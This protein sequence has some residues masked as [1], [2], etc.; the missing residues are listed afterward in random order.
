MC[1]FGAHHE[2]GKEL[3]GKILPLAL[4]HIPRKDC[5]KNS[6][7]N[8]LGFSAVKTCAKNA[9]GQLHLYLFIIFFISMFIWVLMSMIGYSGCIPLLITEMS[10]SYFTN[11]VFLSSSPYHP[12]F[13]LISGDAWSHW[14]AVSDW[15]IIL[16]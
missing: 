6:P 8:T 15:K 12:P 13:T 14:S 10:E 5:H 9:W 4:Q 7:P 1:L 11:N 2:S 16:C 3:N